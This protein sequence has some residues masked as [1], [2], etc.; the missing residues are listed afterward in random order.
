ML[1]T[2]VTTRTDGS[3]P[4]PLMSALIALQDR[5]D[6]A[7][8]WLA[9]AVEFRAVGQPQQAIEACEASLKLDPKSVDAWVMIAELARAV[10]HHEIAD[11][12]IGILRTLA[13]N[14]ARADSL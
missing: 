13:P 14:D 6:D 4:T 5:E 10:G 1:T 11:E 12:A 3:V 2:S 8:C 7:S 9:V